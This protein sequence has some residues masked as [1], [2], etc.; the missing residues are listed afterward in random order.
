MCFCDICIYMQTVKYVF[1]ENSKSLTTQMVLS[2]SVI[3]KICLLSAL[4]IFTIFS[5]SLHGLC[6]LLFC[7][8]VIKAFVYCCGPG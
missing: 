1:L 8:I 2:Y 3:T 5:L 7:N 6:S 4:A